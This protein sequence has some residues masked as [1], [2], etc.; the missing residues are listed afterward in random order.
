MSRQDIFESIQR[1][2]IGEFAD[3][4]EGD[5]P[6]PGHAARGGLGRDRRAVDAVAALRAGVLGQDVDADLQTGR[7]VLELA[8]LV[9]ADADLGG[10]AAGAGLLRLGEV[11]LDADVG[12]VLEPGAARGTGR[13]GSWRGRV[14]VRGGREGLRF[15]LGGEIE[16][17]SLIRV[18]G[19][20]LAARSEETAS[21]QCQG[22]EQ[23]GVRLLEAVIVLGGRREDALQLVGATTDVLGL[24]VFVLGPAVLVLGLPPQ[25]VAAA[26]QV[27]E[28]P[29]ALGRIIGQVRCHVHDTDYTRISLLCKS[30]SDEFSSYFG[31]I[32]PAGRNRR[33]RRAAFRSMP[34]RIMASCAA[35]SSMPSRSPAS[36]TWKQPTSSRLY[37]MAKPS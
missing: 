11:V 2:V 25:R 37:Q 20:S 28:E 33:R 35:S 18:V 7:D 5:Q 8:G 6:G 24:V 21:E 14:V 32:R 9:L 17:M 30:L 23:L 29:P 26:E 16:E 12:E 19:A 15:G 27:L 4:H 22:L 1:Q 13:A 10:P 36:G 31:G 3:D 34:E